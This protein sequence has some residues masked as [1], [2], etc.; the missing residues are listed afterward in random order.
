MSDGLRKQLGLP[1]YS[2]L[3]AARSEEWRVIATWSREHVLT[4]IV[5][6]CTN[7]LANLPNDLLPQGLKQSLITQFGLPPH[8][9]GEPS[10][11]Q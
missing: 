4:Q 10:P 11:D 7:T 9:L 2:H 8:V 5:F 1:A 6:L 3:F